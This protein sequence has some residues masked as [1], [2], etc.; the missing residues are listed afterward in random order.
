ME[1]V[2]GYRSCNG[3]YFLC[4]EEEDIISTTLSILFF[5]DFLS[6]IC[7]TKQQLFSVYH[8]L[9]HFSQ[10]QF[11]SATTSVCISSQSGAKVSSAITLNKA[12]TPAWFCVIGVVGRGSSHSQT[13]CCIQRIRC[14]GFCYV[15]WKDGEEHRR[16]ICFVTC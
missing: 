14:A 11:W 2:V 16:E 3:S 15:G 13:G 4:S 8:H 5:L 9:N 6:R 10:H 12:K 7:R 1:I